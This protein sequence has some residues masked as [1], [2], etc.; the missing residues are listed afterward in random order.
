ME[1]IK[2]GVRADGLTTFA[3]G[4]LCAVLPAGYMGSSLVGSLM[5]FCSF[6]QKASLYFAVF[7]E[8]SCLFVILFSENLFTLAS[9]ILIFITFS[10]MLL[11]HRKSLYLKCWIGCMGVVSSMI[12]SS[13]ILSGLVFYQDPRSD[14]Y[15][16]SESCL[17]GFPSALV[18]FAWWMASI[19]LAY[20]SIFLATS[21]VF[22]ENKL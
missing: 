1:S 3:G 17:L 19:L 2:I 20:V 13:S 21:V 18:G 14:A 16:F 7:V 5:L 11:Y 8:A 22:Q 4:S 6:S 9:S 10:V 12:S 15:R